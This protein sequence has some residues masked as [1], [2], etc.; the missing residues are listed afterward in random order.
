MCAANKG[1]FSHAFTKSVFVLIRINHYNFYKMH[2]IQIYIIHATFV[3]A[4]RTAAGSTYL[5]C[6]KDIHGHRLFS[7]GPW[8]DYYL[9]L[10]SCI[11]LCL[12]RNAPFAGTEVGAILVVSIHR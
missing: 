7:D 4:Y 12:F 11:D 10:S 5:G 9:T 8:A 3:H 1:Y 6:F 2:K